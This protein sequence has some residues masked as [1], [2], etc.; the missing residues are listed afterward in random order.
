MD[1][2]Q[3]YVVV[4]PTSLFM[5]GR[6]VPGGQE[7]LSRNL[8][9]LAQLNV[10]INFQVKVAHSIY[11]GE[12]SEFRRYP[13][14]E[15]VVQEYS[16]GNFKGLQE[17]D[18]VVQHGALLNRLIQEFPPTTRYVLI[19][20]PD[21][22]AIER[23]LISNCI[24][25]MRD[26]EISVVGV[27]YP[28]WYP[29]EYS[30]KTPQLYFSIFDTEKIDLLE[31]D[32][33]AGSGEEKNQLP[34]PQSS[35]GFALKLTK[36]LRD[37]LLKMHVIEFLKPVELV[38]GTKVDF[39]LRRFE[40]NPKDTGWRIGDLLEKKNIQFKVLPNILK[41]S[42]EIPGFNQ[43]EYLKC[44]LDLSN[45]DRHLGWH[46][47]SQGLL[48]GR[49]I[50][51]QGFFPRM[52]RRFIGSDVINKSKWPPTSLLGKDRV[53]NSGDLEIVL[54]AIPAADFYAFNGK[55]CLFHIGSKG[56]GQIQNEIDTLDGVVAE[57][58]AR[59]A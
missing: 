15:I 54:Q 7:Y 46:F 50:G 26:F 23:N 10:E 16:E 39:L 8:S 49:Q 27:P 58:A 56:K 31:L 38:L 17:L 34:A 3:L 57:F 48:E 19:L 29:K 43:S 11:H 32:L 1:T 4:G 9:L 36:R 53:S 47:L 51:N 59:V 52:M 14:L 5:G 40:I 18:P 21:C 42:Y 22:Y 41:D 12:L 33:R 2:I 20:D 24:K 13:N 6:T 30:W 25:E 44:N 55:F 45:I 37:I 28:A 35:G